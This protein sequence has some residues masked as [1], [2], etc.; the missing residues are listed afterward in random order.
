MVEKLTSAF[1]IRFEDFRKH[2]ADCQL[3][4][5][6]FNLVVKNIPFSFQLEIIE[7]QVNVDHKRAYHENDLI[8]FYR[9]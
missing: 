8:T 3:F 2:N 6:P 5:H 9:S 4:A 7:L 1:E